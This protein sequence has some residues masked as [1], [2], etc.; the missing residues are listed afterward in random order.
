M[1]TSRGGEAALVIGSYFPTLVNGVIALVPGSYVN[2]ALPNTGRSAWTLH[3]L[4]LPYARA[5]GAPAVAVD[6][7]AVIPVERIRG[8]VLLTCG[9][10]DVVWPSCSNVDD[11]TRRLTE[12]RFG[13]PVTALRY[14]NAGHA[15]SSFPPYTS[16][17]N[18]V[19]KEHGGTIA[20]TESSNVEFHRKLLEL[21]AAQ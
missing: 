16:I 5:P 20:G 3:G 11:I 21:L 6:P 4:D 1:G 2:S 18:D 9:G 15:V 7:K 17:T 12:H 10:L 8:P 14:P 13:Y 19:V